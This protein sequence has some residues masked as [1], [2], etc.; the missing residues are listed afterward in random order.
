MA[1]LLR[2]GSQGDEVRRLQEILNGQGYGLDVDGIYG[3]QTKNAVKQYQS[4]N[5]LD[6]DG[7][8]GEQTWASLNALPNGEWGMGNGEL[9][10]AAENTPTL[11]PTET[12]LG[13]AEAGRPA[14]QQSQTLT[15]ALNTLQAQLGQKPGEYQSPYAA[16]IEALYQKATNREPFSYDANADPVYQMYRDRYRENARRSMQD[17]M[18]EAAALSG[19]YGNTYAQAAAQQAYDQQMN[20]LNDILPQL[21]DQAYSRYSAEGDQILQQLA[22]AQQMDQTGYNRWADQLAD[23]YNQLGAQQSLANDMYNREYGEYADALNA[24]QNDRAYYYQKAQDELA[25]QNFLAQLAMAGSS[26]GSSGGGGGGGSRS[27]GGS[28]SSGSG[29]V[30]TGANYKTVL[31]TAKGLTAQKA[32]DYVERMANQGYITDDEGYRI[33]AVE[34]GLDVGQYAGGSSGNSGGTGNLSTNL[35]SLLNTIGQG[36]ASTVKGAVSRHGQLVQQQDGQ[37]GA[38]SQRVGQRDAEYQRREGDG[39]GAD[40]EGEPGKSHTEPVERAANSAETEPVA[41]GRAEEIE[42]VKEIRSWPS[43]IT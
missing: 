22:L 14:F 29:S 18:A 12:A 28:K 24:W 43:R 20:G 40:D 7:I 31:N 3:S 37:H 2:S 17:T 33:L 21:Y 39:G 1:S 38:V 27:S 35:S 19:G 16:Q 6:A 41:A 11:S 32:Y 30:S 4:A 5:G 9:S 23:Y 34:L 25:Q 13:G 36:V 42:E 10:A 26:G 15:D 8:V